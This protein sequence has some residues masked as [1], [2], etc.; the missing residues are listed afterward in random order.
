RTA[1]FAFPGHTEFFA[2]R[3]GAA[4]T[5]MMFAGPTLKVVLATVHVPLARVP[6]VLTRE[7]VVTATV[8]AAESLE[9][10]FGV[11]RARVGVLG[12]NPHAGEAGLLGREEI[13]VI[14]PAIEECRRRL[15]GRCDIDGPLSPDSG[16]RAGCDLYVA[17][18]HDQG[19]IPVK[20]VDFERSVNVTL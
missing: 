10:D 9:R 19:L 3:L 18:Y 12:L 6:A 1:G 16:F 2:D 4:A 17:M 7:R 14:T 15:A 13:E 11:E 5:A 8:L 20:L